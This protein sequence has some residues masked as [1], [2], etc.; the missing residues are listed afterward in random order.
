MIIKNK[1]KL[2]RSLRK[3]LD[4]IDQPREHGIVD[5]VKVVVIIVQIK[6]TESYIQ[7]FEYINRL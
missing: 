3:E 1:M 6:R 5:A 4:D 2:L 7:K